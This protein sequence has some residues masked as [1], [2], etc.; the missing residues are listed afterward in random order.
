MRKYPDMPELLEQFM[1]E[2]DADERWVTVREVRERFSLTQHQA[3]TIS[4]FLRRLEFGPFRGFPFIVLRIERIERTSLS[5]P[6]KCRYLV[7][8]KTCKPVP[9]RKG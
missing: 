4:A 3:N 7:R 6:P 2:Q 8:R 5:D 1:D 9:Q